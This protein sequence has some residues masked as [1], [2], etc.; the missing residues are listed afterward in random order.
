M[1]I[2]AY[3]ARFVPVAALILAAAVRYVPISHEEAAAAAGAGWLRTMWRIV[4]PQLRL[5]LAAAWIVVFVLSFGELG[6]SVLIAPPG[7]STLPI[8]IY[9]I[10][11]NAP[12]AQVA[13]LA[14][15]ASAGRL[16][17]RGDS[18]NRCIAPRACPSSGRRGHS[19]GSGSARARSR[20]GCHR[21]TGGSLRRRPRRYPSGA[22]RKR[23]GS[24]QALDD[25]S[26]EIPPGACVVVLG[27]SGCGKTTLL[28]VIAGLDNTGRR[29]DLAGR[30]AGQRCRP[31]TS[32]RHMRDG[33]ASCFRIWLSGRTSRSAESRV[34]PRGAASSRPRFASRKWRTRY[35]VVRIE[36]LIGRYPHELSGGEQ[37]RVALAR[38]W[39]VSRGSCCSTS[40]CRAST[41]TEGDTA[42]GT[43]AA[44]AHPS[45][46]DRIRHPRP[47]RRVRAR[48]FHCGNARR[49]NRVGQRDDAREELP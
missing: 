5:G 33:S 39:S 28:R 1:F 24:H 4:L 44:S 17:S 45:A 26:L 10:I 11:A 25:V 7:E 19:A 6:A 21:E 32:S 30:R 3:L 12:P 23:F 42:A 14:L 29:R 34:R 46:H 31:E 9:T 20:G 2:L 43:G 37:Q 36:T 16:Y 22:S 49:P 47:G 8:R 48:R 18:G 35:A 13:A 41:R 40:R 15:L 38:A 27:P